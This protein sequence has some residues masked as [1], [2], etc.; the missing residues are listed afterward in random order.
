[1]RSEQF[2]LAAR[3]SATAA[4]AGAATLAYSLVEARAYKLRR[5]DVGVGRPAA[6]NLPDLRI[7]HLSDLHL[8]PRDRDR[9]RWISSL[10]TLH[11]DL[12][13]VTGDFHGHAQAGPIA[14]AALEPLLA[15]PGV[16]VHGSND[17]YS[18]KP[19]NPIKYF[20]GPSRMPSRRPLIDYSVL[21]NGLNAGGWTCLDNASASITAAGW[22]ISARGTAD[23]HIQLDRYTAVAGEYPTADLR[24]AVTH[25]PYLRVLDAMAADEPDIILAGHTHGGQICLPWYGA[26][27]TNCDLPRSQASG[28]SSWDG[29]PLHVSA[30][31]GTNPYTP[32]RLACRP[33]ATL[34]TMVAA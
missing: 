34:I 14:L 17:F 11:P 33:T 10:A 3:V 13:V 2:S 29:I 18:P 21:D 7:L 26:L 19:I 16:Y 20:A 30:G 28:L 1:M 31:L 12:V 6:R 8:A 4:A 32:I 25:A 9:V 24:L 15:F 23:A 22:Q 5:V 27:V